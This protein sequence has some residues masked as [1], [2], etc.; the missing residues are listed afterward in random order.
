MNKMQLDDDRENP[1]TANIRPVFAFLGEQS[2]E[3]GDR[4]EVCWRICSSGTIEQ[5]AFTED[6]EFFCALL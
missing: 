3:Q 6:W 2:E 4:R 1:F 5:K